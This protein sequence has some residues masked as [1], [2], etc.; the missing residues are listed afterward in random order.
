MTILRKFLKVKEHKI[1]YTLPDDFDCD[2]V[3]IIIIP[4]KRDEWE[5]W[6]DN[7]IENFSKI[8]LG[9]SNN[10]FDDEEEDYSKW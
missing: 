4:K 9:L 1:A 7:E 2:E 6:N 10:N 5:Y 8:S 3:E